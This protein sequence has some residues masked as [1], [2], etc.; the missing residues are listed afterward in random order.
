MDTITIAIIPYGEYYLK[1]A[2]GNPSKNVFDSE[3]EERTFY[4]YKYESRGTVANGKY[5]NVDGSWNISVTRNDGRHAG[6]MKDLKEVRWCLNTFCFCDYEY[7]VTGMSNKNCNLSYDER[8]FW[9]NNASYEDL[10]RKWRFEPAGS[11]W[12]IGEIGD[13]YEKVLIEKSR[14]LPVHEIVKVS[15]S[16]GWEEK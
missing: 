16:I 3:G 6:W 10:L 9:I 2:K 5:L 1:I 13:Y 4:I 8:V 7:P 14:K 11:N 15:K 12:F